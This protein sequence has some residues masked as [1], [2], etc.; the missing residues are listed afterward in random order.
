MKMKN[1]AIKNILPVF[2]ALL[3]L[4]LSSSVING[5]SLKYTLPSYV[6]YK[7]NNGLTIYLMEQHNVPLI[8]VSAVFDAG[9]VRD[10]SKQGLASLTAEALMFGTEKFTKQELESNLDFLGASIGTGA[11]LEGASLNASFMKKDQDKVLEMTSQVLMKPAFN[12]QEF[13]KRFARKKVELERA[14]ESA[15]QV[16]GDYYSHF[17]YGTHPYGTAVGGTPKSIESIKVQDLKDFYQKYY[18]LDRACLAIV[19]DFDIAEMKAQVTKY[20]GSWKTGKNNGTPIAA[21]QLNPQSPGVL[22]IDKDNAIET[23]FIIGGKGLSRS[24]PDYIGVQVIN[25]ILGGRFT[26]WLNDALRVNAGLT[27]GASSNFTF[28]KLGGSFSM[29]SYTRNETTVKAIDM[30]IDVLNKLHTTGINEETLLSAKNYMKG[31][32]PPRY[33]TNASKARLLAEMFTYGFDEKFINNFEKNVDAVTIEKSKELI[34]KY[35]PSKNLQ[36]VLI[37]KASEI[38]DQVKKYGTLVEKKIK[39]EGY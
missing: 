18:T 2:I 4:L 7:L 26:S 39:D 14:K 6:K 23:R 31:G 38:R 24:N 16:I 27:Y 25:T 9:A 20:F 8:V 35:F 5:Q 32:F 30:A 12:E 28:N 37:G 1:S 34:S 19:G 15:G 3:I 13:V 29:A 17:L 11:S 21:P 33:E 36:F 22:L 10:G